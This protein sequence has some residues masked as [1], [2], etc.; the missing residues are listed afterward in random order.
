MTEAATTA[1]ITTL[2]RR[3]Y[4]QE[5]V[6]RMLA[7]SVRTVK[8]L[9]ATGELPCRRIGRAVRYADADLDYFVDALENLP[10]GQSRR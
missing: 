8:E 4:T 3:L 5:E 10:Y 2:P 1:D 9:T 7:L 6:A